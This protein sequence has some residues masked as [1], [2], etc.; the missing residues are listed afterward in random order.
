[1]RV[2]TGFDRFCQDAA[3]SFPLALNFSLPIKGREKGREGEGGFSVVYG[4]G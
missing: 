3:F 4:G 1:M 2:S